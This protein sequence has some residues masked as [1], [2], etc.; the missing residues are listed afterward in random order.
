MIMRFYFN[1]L[2]VTDVYCKVSIG[3][4]QDLEF[5]Y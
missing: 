1:L 4:I 2:L 5:F 3:F